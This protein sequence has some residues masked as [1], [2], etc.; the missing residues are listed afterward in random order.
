MLRVARKV[1]VIS[2]TN[3]FR[4]GPFL[5]RLAKLLLYKLNL[6]NAFDFLQTRGKGYQVFEGDGVFYSYSVYDNLKQI[7]PWAES[8]E[9]HSIGESRSSSSSQPML[10]S[11]IELL[12]AV[13]K[14]LPSAD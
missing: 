3:R 9:I 13:R 2:D 7:Q 10:G 11:G 5:L 1:L 12:I 14:K 4:Q 6:W 8:I